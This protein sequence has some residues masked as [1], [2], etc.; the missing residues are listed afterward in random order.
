MDKSEVWT[1]GEVLGFAAEWLQADRVGAGW[2]PVGKG[3]LGLYGERTGVWNL[4]GGCS[5]VR[6]G[7][8]DGCCIVVGFSRLGYGNKG[9]G[10][11][12]GMV[13]LRFHIDLYR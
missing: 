10:E 13:V 2:I 5:R 8:G 1:P 11:N 4:I 7:L 6:I 3:G 9:E 12:C